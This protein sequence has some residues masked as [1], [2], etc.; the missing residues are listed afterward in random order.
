MVDSPRQASTGAR[1]RVK[2]ETSNVLAERASLKVARRIVRSQPPL[3]PSR[4]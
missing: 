2:P 4:A 3:K 1:L